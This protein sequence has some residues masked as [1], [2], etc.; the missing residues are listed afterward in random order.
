MD[1]KSEDIVEIAKY[2]N[3]IHHVN[4]RL[5]VRVNKDIKKYSN[6]ITIEDI[7][8]LPSKINGIKKLKVNKIVGSITIEYD[9]DIFPKEMWEDLIAGR[10]LEALTKKINQL[11]KEIV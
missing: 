3:I 4:G 8:T 10:N 1:I 9:N 11:Y 6:E 5:R 2:F 7:Q